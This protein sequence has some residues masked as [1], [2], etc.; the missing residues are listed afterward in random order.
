SA[1]CSARSMRARTRASGDSASPLQPPSE[2]TRPT[3]TKGRNASRKD[4]EA[5]AGGEPP[6][7]RETGR[8]A[9]FMMRSLFFSPGPLRL[10]VASMVIALAEDGAADAHHGRAFRDRL[11]EIAAHAH[12][13][14]GEA[15]QPEAGHALL[16]QPAQGGERAPGLGRGRGMGRDGHES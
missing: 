2:T 16:A 10:S 11:R 1:A 7:R 13:Q 6:A 12:R 9:V 8:A 4:A 5:P 15:R 3:T 14:L